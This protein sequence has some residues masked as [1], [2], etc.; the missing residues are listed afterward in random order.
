MRASS[1]SDQPPTA[2]HFRFKPKKKLAEY[3]TQEKLVGIYERVEEAINF[4]K[5]LNKLEIS[6]KERVNTLKKNN[7]DQ[8]FYELE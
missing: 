8:Q 6:E 4:R 7:I 3:Q 2:H 5:E 1:N